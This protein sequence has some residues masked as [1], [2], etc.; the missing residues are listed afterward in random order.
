MQVVNLDC[1]G[2]VKHDGHIEITSS[3]LVLRLKDSRAPTIAWPLNSVRKYGYENFL[4][5]FEAGRSSPVGEGIFAFK[6]KK[7]KQMFDL[8]KEELIKVNKWQFKRLVL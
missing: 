6:S 5:C 3:E 7:A 1:N 4:F 2:N 8:L